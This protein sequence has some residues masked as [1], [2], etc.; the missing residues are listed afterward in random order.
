LLPSAS[1]NVPTKACDV[2][3]RAFTYN[4]AALVQNYR[5]AYAYIEDRRRHIIYGNSKRSSNPIA[6][7]TQI[8]AHLTRLTFSG[9][10]IR[11]ATFHLGILK[12]LQ[13]YEDPTGDRLPQYNFQGF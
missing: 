2:R 10:G 5:E 6:P 9:E 12:V 4:P 3:Q 13:D 1:Q 7:V 8:T 11:S